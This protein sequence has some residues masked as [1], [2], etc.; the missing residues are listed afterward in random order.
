MIDDGCIGVQNIACAAMTSRVQ[1][2][3]EQPPFD[4]A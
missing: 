4:I 1:I 2:G 3:V